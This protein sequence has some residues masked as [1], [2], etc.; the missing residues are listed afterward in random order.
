MAE[1]L[2][3]TG[4]VGSDVLTATCDAAGATGSPAL[5]AWLVSLLGIYD[6]AFVK[7]NVHQF[8]RLFGARYTALLYTDAT[9]AVPR[10]VLAR[11]SPRSM[12]AGGADVTLHVYGRDFTPRAPI[13]FNGGPETTVFV[14]PT[15]LTTTVVGATATTPGDSPVQVQTAAPGGG[16]SGTGLFAILAPE[17]NVDMPVLVI[18]GT[19]GSEQ[20]EVRCTEADMEGS[21]PVQAWLLGELGDHPY[22]LD[23]MREIAPRLR[24]MFG[25]TL[26][27]VEEPD[28]VPVPEPDP[29][30]PAVPSPAPDAPVPPPTEPQS[31]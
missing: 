6:Y 12:P 8:P 4:L 9:T 20:Y 18:R 15:E 31:V 22:R 30:A 10:P 29:P 14:G 7:A 16:L 11:V 27:L 2:L 25:D 3:M 17:E 24:T 1:R 21:Q 26:T 23:T 28:E 19:L 13:V 5:L